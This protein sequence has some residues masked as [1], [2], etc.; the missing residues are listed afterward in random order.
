MKLK[1]MMSLLLAG[2]L[3]V[4]VLAGCGNAPAPDGGTGDGSSSGSQATS[5]TQT[6]LDKTNVVTRTMFSISSNDKLDRAIA[7]AAKN[8]VQ[9][10]KNNGESLAIV[11]SGWKYRQLAATVMTGDDVKY[12]DNGHLDQLANQINQDVAK[13]EEDVTVY[14]MYTVSRVMD[15]EWIAGEVAKMLDHWASKLNQD[16]DAAT[17]DYTV[18]VAMADSLAGKEADRT[19]DTVVIGVAVTCDYT[20]IGY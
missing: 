6:V 16:T 17:Y 12:V 7:W 1:R 2:V 5:L 3:A 11:K 19:Q 13:T 8:H 9:D 15:D 18:R 20:A 10:P 4:G 14:T